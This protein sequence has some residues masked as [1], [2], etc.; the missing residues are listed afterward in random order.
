MNKAVSWSCLEK[1][2][3][4]LNGP[5]STEL[6]VSLLYPGLLVNSLSSFPQ[7]GR[8]FLH[9]QRRLL[10]PLLNPFPGS[11]CDFRD[12]HFPFVKLK[13]WECGSI[14]VLRKPKQH[15]IKCQVPPPPSS[16]SARISISRW[17]FFIFQLW[18][19]WF[20][21]YD[22]NWIPL[23]QR[24]VAFLFHHGLNFT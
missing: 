4:W 3:L 15:I 12:S 16:E 24:S 2:C 13:F 21:C 22:Y 19:D 8:H 6:A 18:D 1:L 5:M 17:S 10:Q 14:W 7:T 20:F 9:V 23:S 11:F